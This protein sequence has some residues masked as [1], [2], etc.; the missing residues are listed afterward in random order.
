MRVALVN[1]LYHP[2][3]IGGAERSVQFLAE[4]LGSWLKAWCRRAMRRWSSARAQGGGFKWPMSM[5]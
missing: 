3:V 5:R 4:G 2:Y 1:T